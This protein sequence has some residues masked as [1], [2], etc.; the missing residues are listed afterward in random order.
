ML[1]GDWQGNWAVL[2]TDWDVLETDWDV[3]AD[4]H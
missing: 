4:F 1:H 3:L 2:E